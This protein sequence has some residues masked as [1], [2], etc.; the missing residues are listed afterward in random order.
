LRQI[1]ASFRIIAGT[2][3]LESDDV[4]IGFFSLQHKSRD[5]RGGML[6]TVTAGTACPATQWRTG[7]L[8]LV[9]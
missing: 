2:T 3:I 9:D 7:L 6:E 4:V 8:R 5:S 1:F